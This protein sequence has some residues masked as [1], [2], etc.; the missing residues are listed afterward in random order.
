MTT[1]STLT[2]IYSALDA[3]AVT[4]LDKDNASATATCF[5]LS[6]LPASL[7]TAHLPCRLLLPLG[8]GASGS[9]NLQL[10]P[11]PE[12]TAQWQITD[13]FLLETA[14]RSEGL[15]IQA[16]VLMRYVK[17]Y[18]DAI[19]L[20]WQFL[21]QWQSEALTSA[22]SIVPGV[23]EYPAGGGTYFFGVKCDIQVTEIF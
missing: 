18:A 12:I 21:Y 4:Y 15:Y 3:M 23:Y 2:E 1:G 9:P 8:Q 6:E 16:P 19:A 22:V 5:N 11:G 13:L 7:Q 14:A 10:G 20:K 17:A